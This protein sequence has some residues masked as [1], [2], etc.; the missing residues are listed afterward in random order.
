MLK[1]SKKSRKSL[2]SPVPSSPAPVPVISTPIQNSPVKNLKRKPEDSVEEN[3]T[4]ENDDLPKL[5]KAEKG[6]DKK[7][8]K[9]L[10]KALVRAHV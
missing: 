7:R 8:K 10:I 1:S 4:D 9:E 5:S 6:K 3:V 2:N